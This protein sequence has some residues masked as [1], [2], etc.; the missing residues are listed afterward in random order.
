MYMRHRDRES[1][2][3]NLFLSCLALKNV[4]FWDVTL[5]GSCKNWRFGGTCH[6]HLQGK[7]IP[8]RRKALAVD[9]WVRK[10][11]RTSWSWLVR[12]IKSIFF[13][14]SSFHGFGCSVCLSSERM[15]RATSF[16]VVDDRS[17]SNCDRLYTHWNAGQ[18][19]LDVPQSSLPLY[20]NYRTVSFCIYFVH[21]SICPIEPN[22]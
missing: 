12:C 6:L 16:L 14:A 11:D 18:S 13:E 19:H 10:K 21:L 2:E 20:F 8:E 3:T 5:C 17:R 1:R 7:E 9:W 15:F 4:I 22:I